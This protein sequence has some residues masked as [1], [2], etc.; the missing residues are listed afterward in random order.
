MRQVPSRPHRAHLPYEHIVSVAFLETPTDK[1]AACAAGGGAVGG[2][3]GFLIAGT[4]PGPGPHS[5]SPKQL[6]SA[7]IASFVRTLFARGRRNH[8]TGRAGTSRFTC[9]RRW[10]WL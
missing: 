8:Y 3:I 4:D 9:S 5:L 7:A 10:R 2:I 6:G 1:F